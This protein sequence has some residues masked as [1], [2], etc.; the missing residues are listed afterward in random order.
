Y[1]T[2]ATNSGGVAPFSW[3]ITG[4]SLPSGLT[5]TPST[6]VISGT[7]STAGTSNFTIRVADSV[8]ASATKAL[9][10]TIAGPPVVTTTSLQAATAGASYSQ[11]LQVTGGTSPFAWSVVSGAIPAGLNLTAG[12]G[13]ISGTPTTEGTFSFIVRVTDNVGS[14]AL[15]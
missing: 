7:P 3:S 4:G 5:I 12:T 10:I 9:S 14:T 1:S 13:V 2:T 15:S 8:G 6:D 11:T